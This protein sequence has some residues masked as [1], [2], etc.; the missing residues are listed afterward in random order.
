MLSGVYHR[1][2][3][4]ER[5]KKQEK[6]APMHAISDTRRLV[7]ESLLFIK[8]D[9][10]KMTTS[11]QSFKSHKQRKKARRLYFNMQRLNY[12]GDII[13]SLIT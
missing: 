3:S 5:E 13:E 4:P 7:P 9:L 1:E 11:V 10:V 12:I 8:P 6:F 2:E